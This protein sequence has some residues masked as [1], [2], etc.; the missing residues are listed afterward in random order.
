ME[1]FIQV[2]KITFLATNFCSINRMTFRQLENSFGKLLKQVGRGEQE[3]LFKQFNKAI[4]LDRE[5]ERQRGKRQEERQPWALRK[6]VFSEFSWWLPNWMIHKIGRKFLFEFRANTIGWCFHWSIIWSIL[7]QQVFILSFLHYSHECAHN[8]MLFS[9]YGAWKIIKTK[10]L[11]KFTWKKT[12]TRRWIEFKCKHQIIINANKSLSW[13]KQ[14]RNK[15]WCK[16]HKYVA[17][18]R[19]HIGTIHCRINGYS[20]IVETLPTKNNN[21]SN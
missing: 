15:T 10:W 2:D 3:V 8:W 11:S 20:N 9:E 1:M 18:D 14:K 5:T 4:Q 12:P 16:L 13:V 6:K 7:W 17:L 21:K 19:V